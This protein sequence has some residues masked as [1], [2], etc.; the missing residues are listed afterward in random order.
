MWD[1]FNN[2]NNASAQQVG[3]QAM[4]LWN[5]WPMAQGVLDVQYGQDQQLVADRDAIQWQVP[6]FGVVNCN[7]DASFYDMEGATGRGWCVR[8]HRSRFL[9]A[10]TNTMQARLHTLEG[11]AMAIK[12]AMDEM[13]QRGFSHVIF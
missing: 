9:I 12:E 6:R 2:N 4:H 10:G 3:I 7:V 11:E 5:E 13:S 1:F 8:D